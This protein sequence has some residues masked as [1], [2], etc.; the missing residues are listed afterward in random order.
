MRRIDTFGNL[1]EEVRQISKSHY[2]ET[3]PVKGMEFESL[4]QM[5]IMGAEVEVLPSAQRLFANK[6][7]VP[8]SYLARCPKDLQAQNLNYWLKQ[9]SQNRDSLFCRF[10]GAKL[11]A[12]FTE[13]YVVMDNADMLEHMAINGFKPNDEVHYNLDQDML[14]VKVPDYSKTFGLRGDNIVPGSSFANSEV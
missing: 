12:V 3:L 10:D 14:V 9:E 7:H 2:D 13:K 8:Y 6:L 4:D 5:I 11:R 1:I